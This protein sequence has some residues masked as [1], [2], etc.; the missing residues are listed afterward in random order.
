MGPVHS[1]LSRKR[2]SRLHLQSNKLSKV[3]FL[4]KP[5]GHWTLN[6]VCSLSVRDPGP[7][8]NEHSKDHLRYSQH[9]S[10]HHLLRGPR[11]RVKDNGTA[12]S[13]NE[14]KPWFQ[15]CTHLDTS[16]IAIGGVR[17]YKPHLSRTSCSV[18]SQNSAT[19]TDTSRS[20]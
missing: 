7:G 6:R 4:F 16:S 15:Q 11:N 20:S 3:L 19:S 10:I 8:L 2:R 9:S 17:R 14:L 12:N 5:T 1:F 13:F 18:H